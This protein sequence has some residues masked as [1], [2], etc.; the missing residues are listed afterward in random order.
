MSHNNLLKIQSL[1]ELHRLFGLDKPLHPLVSLVKLEDVRIT[2]GTL[3]EFLVL[4]FYKIAYKTA[5]GRVKYGQHYYDFGEGGLVFTAPNQPFE[6]PGTKVKAGWLLFIHPD[7]LRP[8]PLARKMKQYGY[9]SYAANEALHLSESEQA[10]ILSVLRMISEELNARIDDYSQDVVV[11]QIELLLTYSNRFY[12][13][14]FV[15]RKA[16]NNDL[17][18]KLDD[19]LAGYFTSGRSLTQGIPTVQ[20]LA[21]ELHLSPGYL[22][23]ML[24]TLTGQ[25]AQQHIHQQLID[26]AKEQ[27]STTSL[28][29]SE[30]AYALGFEHPQSFSKLFKIKTHMSPVAFRRAFS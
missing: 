25:N 22:S 13:R 1:T 19:L 8:Y 21:D 23:D 20:Y 3:P 27:L 29:V 17:L 24:R 26:Y 11:S 5:M 7:F 4:D 16:V 2:P 10:T 30:V 6:S 12:K 9:F 28:S 14:Q 15:T 18:Q